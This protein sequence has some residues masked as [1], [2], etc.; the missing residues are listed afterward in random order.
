MTGRIIKLRGDRHHEVQS[1]LPWYL[2]G[3]LDAD[4]RAEVEAHLKDCPECQ[5]ELRDERILGAEIATLPIGETSIA[6]APGDVEH[7]WALM[8]RRIEPG[9]A[10]RSARTGAARW[11]GW[12]GWLGAG[13][14]AAVLQWRASSPWLRW[15]AVG[16]MALLLLM[17]AFVLPAAR[18][19]QLRYHALGAAPAVASGNIVVIFRPDTRERELRETLKANHARVVDGPTATDAYLLHVPAAERGAALARLRRQPRIELAEPVD[20]GASP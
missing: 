18:H 8:R 9:P 12:R 14:D 1:L 16:Q 4:E 11:A 10:R 15:A 6:G 19:D 17:A 20:S 3:R 13:G 2:N 5:A 7:D